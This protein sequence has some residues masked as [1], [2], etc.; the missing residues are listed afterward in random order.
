MP[1]NVCNFKC[2][3]CFPG[4]FEGTDKAPN[5]LDLVIQNFNHLINY[6]KI[7]RNKSKFHI[8]I[9]GGEPTV[10][11][12]LEKFIE[13]MKKNHNAYITIISNG[14]RS[15]RWWKE[16]GPLIDNLVLSFH[17]AQADIDHHIQV[18]DIMFAYKK[19]VTSLVLM[20]PLIWDKCVLAVEQMKRKSKYNW[21]I[22][23]KELVEWDNNK[24]VYTNEQKKY[25][26]KEIKRYPGL[27]WMIKNFKLLFD[28]SIKV[29]ESKAIL[30]NKKIIW[31][32]PHRYIN[33]DWTNFNGWKCNVGLDS[34]FVDSK[35]FIKGAC[36]QKI[37][38]LNYQFNILDTDFTKKYAPQL[39]PSICSINKC[40]CQPDTH[41]TKVKL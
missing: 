20:D 24:V 26:A 34:V 4:S 8:K 29:F 40:I 17:V 16:N 38:N 22:Q 3:Y 9:L 25:L 39:V 5:D 15:L 23:A 30:D 27:F 18:A 14:S 2:R 35:G 41:I 6:Y 21:F 37:Y 13:S 7:H 19:K 31:A 12:G 10:Y 1:H 11:K 28:G 32:R 36:G 33:E